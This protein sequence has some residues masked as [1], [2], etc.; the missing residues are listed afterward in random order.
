M[1]IVGGPQDKVVGVVRLDS[2]S[3]AGYPGLGRRSLTISTSASL[4]PGFERRGTGSGYPEGGRRV[5]R[6]GKC[7]SQALGRAR[8]ER[9]LGVRMFVSYVAPLLKLSGGSIIKK[10]KKK[11]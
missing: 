3:R 8:W 9:H 2:Q 4:I 1:S 6:V 5:G 7:Y 11:Q 10:K